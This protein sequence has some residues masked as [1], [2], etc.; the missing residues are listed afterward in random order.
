MLAEGQFIEVVLRKMQGPD[1]D[2][3]T[4]HACGNAM[5]VSQ[6]GPF[7]NVGCPVCGE[8][9]RVKREF[10]PY[11][12]E[13]R[14]SIG[15]M[16]TVFV[17][18]DRTLNRE[19]AIKVLN[20]QWSADERRIAAF[21]E[22]ARLTASFTHPNVVRV[23][24]TG[25]AFGRFYI[26]MELVPG[27][28]LEHWI[29]QRGRIPE[30]EALVMAIQVVQGL[31][32]AQMAGLIH[33]DMKPG[34]ILLDEKGN[35]KIVDFGLA[36]VTH[37]GAAQAKELWATPYYVPP[38]AVEGKPETF[39]SDM[40]AFGATLYHAL[41]G[42][43]PCSEES[44][45]TDKL[46][47]AKKHVKLLRRAC[48]DL[49][50][51][52]CRIVNRAM[53]YEPEDRYDSYDEMLDLLEEALK[54]LETGEV[55]GNTKRKPF[56]RWIAFAGILGLIGGAAWWM[57]EMVQNKPKSGVSQEAKTK[58]VPGVE[59]S[60]APAA[61][62]FA[63]YQEVK[64]LLFSGDYE[65]AGKKLAELRDQ[66]SVPEPTASWA[67]IEAV[68][69]AGLTGDFDA[70]QKEAENTRRHIENSDGGKDAEIRQRMLPILSAFVKSARINLL[71][72]A[73]ISTRADVLAAMLGGLSHWEQ[74]RVSES[75]MF[76]Q[77]IAQLG[78]RDQDSWF[79]FY[80]NIAGNY[81]HDARLL[82]SG[83]MTL[84]PK[85]AR[86][87]RAAMA[88]AETLLPELKTRGCA[89]GVIRGKQLEW[90][91]R[92]KQF[93]EQ[94]KAAAIPEAPVK[95]VVADSPQQ[96]VI[97][98]SRFAKEGNFA[99]AHRYLETLGN[100][101]LVEKL[102]V[103]VTGSEELLMV[104]EESLREGPAPGD[105]QLKSGMRIRRLSI[106]DSRGLIAV[107]TQGKEHRI[108][109][110]ELANSSIV[111]L[112]R[113]VVQK[114]REP[115]E[116]MRRHELA[117]GFEWLAGNRDVALESARRLSESSPDFQKR[118]EEFLR[119]LP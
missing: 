37:A 47:D 73:K 19:V 94:E 113:T 14:H 107:D 90:A 36:L 100:S 22:E 68:V 31:R 82:E 7:S 116:R 59:P 38:E 99:D 72:E 92:A 49:S 101:E 15:G 4:C 18:R 42:V 104:L 12:L 106:D 33:R 110:S 6:V 78:N 46:R 64:R 97:K 115:Q 76:F 56:S 119:V 69:V 74:G 25:W 26:A 84:I 63:A 35:A 34:N 28:H 111:L 23:F 62:A 16:S 102:D 109:W 41:A 55:E 88:E 81:L 17:A 118:W 48:E 52:T 44:M 83:T 108:A 77:S 60:P 32:A 93:E 27:A 71:E 103:L 13:R 80:Q 85:T 67:G 2:I 50:P 87:A 96:I 45:A 70:A 40:Y 66:P 112:H 91:K 29:T 20:E 79:L 24:R 43:P 65:G 57:G 75:L 1:A 21:V 58:P 89:R 114:V 10:G 51:A 105:F 98:V 11:F 30:K 53:A 54:Q 61:D 39:R 95:K 117:I 9:N 3:T 8:H 86:Q 5:D